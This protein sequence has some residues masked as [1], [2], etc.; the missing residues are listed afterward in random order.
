MVK[1][2]KIL[3]TA[4]SQLLPDSLSLPVSWLILVKKK[5]RFIWIR[6]WNRFLSFDVSVQRQRS[7]GMFFDHR[8]KR[9]NQ[10]IRS[11]FRSL[12][13]LWCNFLTT[14]KVVV[15]R[16][17]EFKSQPDFYYF[18]SDDFVNTI[19]NNGNFKYFFAWNY[20]TIFAGL[21]KMQS[22][23]EIMFVDNAFIHGTHFHFIFL[24]RSSLYFR[25]ATQK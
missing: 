13:S 4:I 9:K 18:F 8:K 23:V 7:Q 14:M 16:F 11:Y 15:F 3:G 17:T 12:Y 20:P 21:C 22:N 6:L 10:L 25:V 5:S 24:L 1:V 2:Q 19:F